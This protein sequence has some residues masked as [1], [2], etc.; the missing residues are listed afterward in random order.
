ME[1]FYEVTNVLIAWIGDKEKT[2][3]AS[4]SATIKRYISTCTEEEKDAIEDAIR[5]LEQKI[6]GGN[7]LVLIAGGTTEEEAIK[8]VAELREQEIRKIKYETENKIYEYIHDKTRK[9]NE[10]RVLIE[11]FKASG[12]GGHKLGGGIKW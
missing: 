1:N 7:V 9:E 6:A 12:I 4:E 11:E 3:S 10:A 5:R 2:I 8:K